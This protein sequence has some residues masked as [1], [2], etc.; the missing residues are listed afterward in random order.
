MAQRGE[1]QGKLGLKEFSC[2]GSMGWLLVLGP[3]WEILGQGKEQGGIG[4]PGTLSSAG[5]R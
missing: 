1:D 3:W 5:T 4:W 2:L